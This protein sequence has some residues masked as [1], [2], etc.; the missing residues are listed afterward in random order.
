[1]PS[2]S[3]HRIFAQAL[4][5]GQS[6]LQPGDLVVPP[7]VPASVYHLPG[8]PTPPHQY[9]RWSNP[10]WSALEEALSVLEQAETVAFPSG[11]AA[12]AALLYSQLRPG[13]RILIPSDG[14][15]TTR[16]FAETFLAPMG[17]TV[18]VCA[19]AEY[20]Q[21]AFQGCQVVWIE[22]PSNPGLDLC[23]LRLVIDRAK[24]AGALTIADNTTA[25]PLG[26]RPL[27]LGADAVISSDTKAISGHSDNLAGHVSSRNAELMRPVREWRK[28]SGAIPGAFEAWLAHRGLETLEVRYDR[29]CS[30]AGEIATRLADH[31]KIRSVRYPGLPSHPSHAIAKEQMIR[32]GSLIGLTFSSKAAAERFVLESEFVQAV[33]SFGGVHTSGERRARWGDQVPEGFVR[34]S[35][36][37]EPTEVLWADMKRVIDSL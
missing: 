13:N 25:T 32:Y 16:A 1:M 26:Q 8:D 20:D 24:T 31:P 21:D 29:M 15:Y 37:C 19:T 17:V 12:I 4:H 9:G 30:T 3:T 18:S 27:D 35:I 10:T 5:H 7:I 23:D 34:L 11:M 14:Y 6:R 2:H 36:G 22:T 33:T 28:L